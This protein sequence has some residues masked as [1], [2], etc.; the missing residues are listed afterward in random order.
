MTKIF[1]RLFDYSRYDPGGYLQPV[2]RQLRILPP[3]SF[4]LLLW[5]LAAAIVVTIL[6]SV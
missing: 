1:N 6:K 3:I 4:D 2:P 5:A